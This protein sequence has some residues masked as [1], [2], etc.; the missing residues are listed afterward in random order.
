MALSF[1]KWKPG[2][3][4]LA[5]GC[6]VVVF[7]VTMMLLALFYY[8]ITTNMMLLRHHYFA[9]NV[10]NDFYVV[11]C[12]LEITAHR[13]HARERMEEDLLTQ[14][15]KDLFKNIGFDPEGS[16]NVGDPPYGNNLLACLRHHYEAR[17]E[18]MPVSTQDVE[19][20]ARLLRD[21]AYRVGQISKMSSELGQWDM[22][23][24]EDY[25][26]AFLAKRNVRRDL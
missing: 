15:E 26:D 19:V 3:C 7:V 2:Q 17:G 6:A 21:V 20:N 4:F 16:D 5:C 13:E 25:K 18:T 24:E 11:Q 1:P 12:A 9:I 14:D 23:V 22:L 8:N 10:K